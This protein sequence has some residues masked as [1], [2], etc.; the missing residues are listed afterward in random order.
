MNVRK[1][2]AQ[3]LT[4]AFVAGGVVA[5]AAPAMASD[6]GFPLYDANG[7]VRSSVSWNSYG[8]YAMACYPSDFT[9]LIQVRLTD[10]QGEQ[11]IVP[12]I[13]D[14]AQCNVAT[15]GGTWSK[16]EVSGQIDGFQNEW[17]E[18]D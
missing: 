15:A 14:W 1:I 7:T 16:I 9:L 2:A 8:H 12:R 10:E 13:V 3:A 6:A 11:Q 5:V 17:H 4:A 18:V